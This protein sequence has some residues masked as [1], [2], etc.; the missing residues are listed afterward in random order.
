MITYNRIS[1]STIRSGSGD[2]IHFRYIGDSG[3]PHNIIIDSG[4]TSS[5]GEFRSLIDKVKKSKEPLDAMF[6]THYDD[7]HIGG[8]LR[9]GDLGFKSYYFNAYDG[10]KQTC[11]LSASQ[12]QKLFHILS[13]SDV[14]NQVLAGDFFEIDGAKIYV[15]AP[16]KDML[17]CAIEMM[18]EK[19]SL[20]SFISDW[21]FSLDDLMRNDISSKDSSVSNKSSIVLT[22][23]IGS[24]RFLFCGDACPD[25]IPR[26]EYDLIKLP[27]H[28]SIRNISDD[29][30]SRIKA[31]SFLI[32]ADG[33]RHPNKQ[34]IAKL[35]AYYGKVTIYSN[36]S[37]WLNSFLKSE[38]MRYIQSELLKFVKI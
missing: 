26:G 31:D 12:N 35:L 6:I 9:I 34:T 15:H 32:C 16:T 17:S 3:N 37:W 36:Y 2:C 22:I 21:E 27:H 5:A 13:E 19:D 29:M 23:E 33:T 30:L 4:P 25:S 14:H 18:Q 38:D 7:D 28:G 11:N 1:I 20:L 10:N 24:N 8:L